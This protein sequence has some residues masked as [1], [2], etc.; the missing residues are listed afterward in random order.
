MRYA[1]CFFPWVGAVVG[2]AVYLWLW[3]CG[4]WGIGSLCRVFVGAAIPL[5]LTGGIHVDGFLDV[6]DALHSYQVR[7][8]KLEI[9]KDPHIGAFALIRLAAYGLVYLG[10]LSQISRDS[11]PLVFCSTFFF[12]RCLSG[13][14]VVSLP[15]ARKEGMLYLFAGSAKKGCVRAALSLQALL[16]AA[17]G[18][19][20]CWPAALAAL[21]ASVGAAALSLRRCVREFG[22]VTGDAAGYALVLSEGA[23]AAALALAEGLGAGL[24]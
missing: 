15:P 20:W 4:L 10:A 5:V 19:C 12:S 8:K 18:L 6:C 9:L 22:G 16:C 23:A 1:L 21:A 11:L 24:F 3:L 17:A 14:A 7:E 2:G 13:L